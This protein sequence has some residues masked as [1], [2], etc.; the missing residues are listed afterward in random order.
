MS[1]GLTD[2]SS[3]NLSSKLRDIETRKKALQD[4]IDIACQ[5]ESSQVGLRTLLMLGKNTQQTPDQTMRFFKA[6][7]DRYQALPSIEIRDLLYDVEQKISLNLSMVLFLTQE[8]DSEELNL[9]LP[10]SDGE[11]TNIDV[12]FTDFRRRTQTAISLRI[13]LQKKGIQI[14]DLVI[15]FPKSSIQRRIQ[16]LDKRQQ[17][18]SKRIATEMQSMH[19]DIATL[20]S[21]PEITQ[22]IID[23]LEHTQT[24]LQKNISH[25]EAG[26]TIEDLPY[27]F[28][29]LSEQ[30]ND[31]STAD[32]FSPLNK[33]N[34]TSA[35]PTPIEPVNIKTSM[36]P[37]RKPR[38]FFMQL[39]TWISTPAHVS[40]DE[41][42]TWQRK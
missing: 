37:T 28:D 30:E 8:E 25:I 29:S 41:A 1:S 40:W 11:E 16:E 33:T 6:I 20:L 39:I 12:L 19:Q 4:I 9:D 21:S 35:S 7:N 18:Y 36:A 32:F 10:F 27:N 2:I 42:K 14:D 22:P 17:H 15:P 31:S 38:G 26:K 34:E 23:E 24:R 3:N 5:L 13:I